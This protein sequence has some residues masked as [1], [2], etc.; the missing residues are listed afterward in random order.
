MK[1]KKPIENMTTEDFKIY[2][3]LFSKNLKIAKTEYTKN[4]KGY[5]GE[6]SS[7]NFQIGLQTLLELGYNP[8]Q[9]SNTIN[10]MFS[11]FIE[12]KEIKDF[13]KTLKEK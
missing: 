10:S 6:A 1:T 8:I 7:F 4:I 3:E 12:N 11:K 2:L 9:D 5:Y 13:M